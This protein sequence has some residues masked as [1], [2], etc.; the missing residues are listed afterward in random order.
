M[1]LTRSQ[2]EAAYMKVFGG[3]V[4]PEGLRH[5]LNEANWMSVAQL[6]ADL[7]NSD[8]YKQQ[9]HLKPGGRAYKPPTTNTGSGSTNTGNTSTTNKPPTTTAPTAPV[10]AKFRDSAAYKAL[11]SDLREFV[12]LA[13][14]LIEVG[15][16]NEAQMFANA[17]KQAQGAADPYYKTLMSLAR[18][19]VLGSIA[20]QNFDY[21]TKSEA[22][23]RARNELMEDVRLNKDFLTLEQ[24]A[25]IAREVRKYD[26]DLLD[27]ADIAA[28]KG[29]TFATG[30][31]SRARA[32][33]LRGMEY[34][35]VVQSS[36]R[37]FNF[38]IRELELRAARGDVEAEKQL[39]ALTGKRNLALQG[40]GR[41]AEEVLGSANLPSIPGFTPTGGAVG[42]IEEEK[43]R[44]IA[45]DT[46]AYLELQKG[47]I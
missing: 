24:Q 47:F 18:A 13:Y 43:R 23:R 4:D 10:S 27:I 21:E 12:D 25:E 35:D 17:L 28:E 40:I 26:E 41:A 29:L 2:I 36:G 14:G 7:R 42:K 31:R 20:E 32:E 16:A 8:E 30:A 37:Q 39:A 6:E 9:L 38:Q 3:P 45:S 44:A 1:P 46:A 11:P 22:I 34:Q 33:E 19:E 15:G 5:F